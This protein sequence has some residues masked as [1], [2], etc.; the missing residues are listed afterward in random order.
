MNLFS[1]RSKVQ[2][3]IINLQNHRLQIINVQLDVSRIEFSTNAM[4]S[5]KRSERFVIDVSIEAL[6][7]AEGF[8][9]EDKPFYIHRKLYRSFENENWFTI[10]PA[11]LV[12]HR[13][14]CQCHCFTR[15]RFLTPNFVDTR[16]TACLSLLLQQFIAYASDSQ[17]I[18]P[19]MIQSID[20]TLDTHAVFACTNRTR[21]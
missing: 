2:T 10:V 6:I 13:E 19:L 4:S 8:S 21:P 11:D 14:T 16:L 17:S 1:R 9:V 15:F 5:D 20:V 18:V 12:V 7:I 3:L